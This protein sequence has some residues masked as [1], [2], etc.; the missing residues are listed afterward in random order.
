LTPPLEV[1]LASN[2]YEEGDVAGTCS[3]EEENVQDSVKLK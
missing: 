2:E 3:K 1:A